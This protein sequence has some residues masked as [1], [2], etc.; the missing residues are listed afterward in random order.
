MRKWPFLTFL[1]R[2]QGGS[3]VKAR[4]LR[5]Y[6]CPLDAVQETNTLGKGGQ[7]GFFYLPPCHMAN[8]AGGALN[9]GINK[10]FRLCEIRTAVKPSTCPMNFRHQAIKLRS[11][12]YSI[13]TLW[14]LASLIN[15]SAMFKPAVCMTAFGVVMGPVNHTAL[16]RPFVFAIKSNGVAFFQLGNSG[17]QINIVRHQ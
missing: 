9:L 15:D 6:E 17:S 10:I 4:F 12:F 5:L 11:L 1:G 14:P 7:V 13:D 2:G 3:F 8:A 16:C